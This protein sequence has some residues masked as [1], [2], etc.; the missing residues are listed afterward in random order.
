MSIS[1]H[2]TNSTIG[3][4]F[5]NPFQGAARIENNDATPPI[6]LNSFNADGTPRLAAP[7][8]ALNAESLTESSSLTASFGAK[9]MVLIQQATS[10]MIRDNREVTFKAGMD[11]AD[12]MEE[13]ADL[14][15]EQ[16]VAQLATSI[17]SGTIQIASGM[18]QIKS[19]TGTLNSSLSET[20]KSL[21]NTKT[22]GISQLFSASSNLVEGIGKSIQTFYEA[23][24]KDLEA[25]Q[26]R[27]STMSDQVKSIT[28]SMQQTLQQSISTLQTIAQSMSET[29]K[30]I[31]G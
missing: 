18:F 9:I 8:T 21:L 24:I 11:K 28:E 31:L 27:L 29:N 17:I 22:T 16:A 25:K 14:Q 26:Q 3:S 13:Q 7:V 6:N 4:S 15:R 23:D 12:L 19:S 1:I 20:Q 2:G 30:R 10:E 5:L